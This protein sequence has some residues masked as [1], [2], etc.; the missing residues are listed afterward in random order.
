MAP[1][2]IAIIGVGKIAQDQHLPVITG[3][4]DFRLAA[5]V[6]G[7]G[8]QAPGVPTFRSAT[9][10]F[11][12][13][14]DLDAVAICTPPSVRYALAR[15]A[16]KAGVHVL[17]EKPPAL[18]VT[19]LTDLAAHAEVAGKVLFTTWHS[20]Y[21]AAVDDLAGRLA[22]QRIAKLHITWKEDVRRWH[23]GQA[24]IWEVGG[25][26]VFDPGINALSILTRIMPGPIFVKDAELTYPENRDMPIAARL[27]FASPLRD[28][29]RSAD[30]RFRLAPDRSADLGLRG[31]HG[32]RRNL[33]S[34][35]R[36][37]G[38]GSGRQDRA[39]GPAGRVRGDLSAGSPTCSGLAEVSSTRN[40]S[41][42][43]PMPS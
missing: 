30:G 21:N 22:G 32:G 38:S 14:R 8:A 43:W 41:N 39:R 16:L 15:E 35:G 24:W 33:P 13:M 17:L 31:D 25:F 11:G 27:V 36:W 34:D 26:G 29:G 19:E 42:S 23:P 18:T 37:R 5:M 4:P 12:A 28:R 2:R 6:S 20:Q 40:R 9:E 7:H 10:L 1:Y 3:N